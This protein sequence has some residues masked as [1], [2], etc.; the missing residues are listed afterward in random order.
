[1]GIFFD[2]TIP[3][4]PPFCLLL[5]P[6]PYHCLIFPLGLSS[7]AFNTWVTLLPYLQNSYSATG[8]LSLPVINQPTADKTHNALLPH[9]QWLWPTFTSFDCIHGHASTGSHTS[10]LPA[11]NHSISN[12][13]HCLL[14]EWPQGPAQLP[15][16][17]FI[18]P[19][20]SMSTCFSALQLPG[21][22]PDLN[23]H[24]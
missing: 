13:N 16:L 21:I 22:F 20:Y 3:P 2:P 10:K 5:F 17:H 14:H 19:K 7:N 8:N 12:H 6:S 11:W 15:L 18:R 24:N 4:T 23:L 1:M 9:L